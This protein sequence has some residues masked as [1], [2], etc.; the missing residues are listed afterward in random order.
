MY[1]Y[2]VKKTFIIYKNII[3]TYKYKLLNNLNYFQT[4]LLWIA[5]TPPRYQ[6]HGLLSSTTPWSWLAVGQLRQK[7]LLT[8]F[9]RPSG[10][11]ITLTSTFM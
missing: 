7:S 8:S 3:L 11:I 2:L 4:L 10:Q 9:L 6:I 1:N 5:C